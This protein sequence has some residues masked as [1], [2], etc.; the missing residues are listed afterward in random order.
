MTA[1]EQSLPILP[2]PFARQKLTA[3]MIT[4]RTPEA[5]Q[6]ALERFNKLRS[7]GTL[8]PGAPR[9]RLFF[10]VTMAGRSGAEPH[11]IRLPGCSM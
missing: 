4:T 3:D 9:G 1:R 8:S 11:L 5:H 6:E 10:P 7:D 2:A